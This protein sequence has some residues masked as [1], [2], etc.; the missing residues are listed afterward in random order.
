MWGLGFSF[1]LFSK[2]QNFG[3]RG[4]RAKDLGGFRV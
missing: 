4:V 3:L 1:G 2:L